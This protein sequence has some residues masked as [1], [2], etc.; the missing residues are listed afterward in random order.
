MLKS[1]SRFSLLGQTPGERPAIRAPRIC[2]ARREARESSCSRRW[3]TGP[4]RPINREL[5]RPIEHALDLAR[6]DEVVLVQSL[7]LL[8]GERDGRVTPAEADIRVM[9]F[10]LGEFPDPMHE[11]QCLAEITESKRPFDAAGIGTPLPKPRRLLQH[12]RII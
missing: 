12:H 9:A 5:S 11:A 8:G 2:H 4:G 1:R 6:H 3:K 10:G 7:D